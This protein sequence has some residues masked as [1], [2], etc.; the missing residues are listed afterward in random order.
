MQQLVGEK[1]CADAMAAP[2]R[3][4]K[5]DGRQE[6]AKM[7][8]LTFLFSHQIGGPHL[9]T[10]TN[11][12][13]EPL[14]S[15][16]LPPSS[17]SSA[18]QTPRSAARASLAATSSANQLTRWWQLKQQ[19]GPTADSVTDAFRRQLSGCCKLRVAFSQRD[20]ASNVTTN[21]AQSKEL[22]VRVLVQMRLKRRHCA[23]RLDVGA[24][25]FLESLRL[26]L[27]QSDIAS[28]LL[29]KR[30]TSGRWPI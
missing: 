4:L 12:G 3:K 22:R 2:E 28:G 30:E 7:A 16:R 26:L 27:L 1:D 19:G 13:M 9:L 10:E 24:P 11:R 5:F 21:G 8:Q 14:E 18:R 29:K 23:G 15:I 17:S 20:T 25:Y 6:A